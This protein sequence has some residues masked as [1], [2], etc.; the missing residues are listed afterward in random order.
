[1]GLLDNLLSYYKLDETSGTVLDAEGT[2]DG[3]NNG[4]TPNV[5]GKLGTAYSFDGTNDYIDMNDVLDTG[6]GA[7][8]VSGW[9]KTSDTGVFKQIV[10]K[11]EAAASSSWEIRVTSSN[12][13]NASFREGASADSVTT[14]TTVTDGSFHFFVLT[15]PASGG[16]VK[17]YLDAE[18]AITATN[19]SRN[20]DNA[21]DFRIGRTNNNI[22]PFNGTI[23]EIGVWDKELSAAEVAELYNS[24]NGL[25]YPFNIII[26]PS[27]LTLSTVD[28]SPSFF[29]DVTQ[30]AAMLM[31]TILGSVV[32]DTTNRNMGSRGTQEILTRFP[33]TVG[34]QPGER[35]EGTQINL[36][37][38]INNTK[39]YDRV[40]LN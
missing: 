35:H 23:D 5:T 12:T 30:G 19:N 4:A 38:R 16:T 3:T 27:A 31:S 21:F 10:G 11:T 14:S 32:V 7:Y 8:S 39:F 36:V 20:T 37:P 1:M 40:G 33:E 6:T 25:A 2:N 34:I 17:L 13:L 18:A 22:F 24:G 15:R 9:F 29:I 28:P 26:S